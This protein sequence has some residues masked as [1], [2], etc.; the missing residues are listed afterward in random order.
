M[1]TFSLLPL[2]RAW[3]PQ[4]AFLCPRTLSPLSY[5][6]PKWKAISRHAAE[7][8]EMNELTNNKRYENRKNQWLVCP[9]GQ[10]DGTKRWLVLSLFI[11][12]FAI[13]FTGL[14]YF[15]VSASWETTS[16]K[17]TRCLSRPKNSRIYSAMTICRRTDPMRQ[18][19]YERELRAHPRTHERN[20]G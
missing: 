17:T 10:M 11:L 2:S 6:A 3:C 13:G 1:N 18:F 8:V 16:S 4:R 20:D 12:V 19:V 7:C 5:V 14:R 9:S 15:K